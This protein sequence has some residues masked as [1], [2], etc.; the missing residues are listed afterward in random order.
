MPI[1]RIENN[2]GIFINIECVYLMGDFALDMKREDFTPKE[3]NAFTYEPERG[4]AL[5]RPAESPD[6]EN[7]V[8]DGYPFYAGELVLK[9]G[10][11]YRKGDAT[12]LRLTG[13][14]ATAHVSVNGREAGKLIFSSYLDLSEHLAEGENVITVTLKNSYRNLM[15]PHHRSPAEPLSVSPRT[16]S[17]EKMWKNGE[18][19]D[20]RSRYAFVRYGI[21]E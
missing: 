19:P 3:N 5:I 20:Y 14:F 4:M 6:A 16:F 11:T 15:G 18:C 21:D 1:I 13:R 2:N 17:F 10:Y 9:S 8:L 7:I 12:V